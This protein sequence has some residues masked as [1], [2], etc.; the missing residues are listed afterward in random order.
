MI[1]LVQQIGAMLQTTSPPPPMPDVLN[2]ESSPTD[3]ERRI[4]DL[5]TIDGPAHNE[6]RP[7][8]QGLTDEE[9]LDSILNPANGESVKVQGNQVRDGNGRI[10]EAQARGLNDVII[11][12]DVLPPPEPIAPWE[13]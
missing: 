9:L 4:G 3:G 12:V 2:N 1:N 7:E 8:L 13:N 5:E 6:P 10:K 11:P